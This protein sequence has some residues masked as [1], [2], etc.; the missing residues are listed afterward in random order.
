MRNSVR[1]AHGGPDRGEWLY[2]INAVVKP[3]L[4]DGD[5]GAGCRPYRAVTVALFGGT[6]EYIAP[7]QNAGHEALVLL[8]RDGV[9]RARWRLRYNAGTKKVSIL[10]TCSDSVLDDEL[11]AFRHDLR[12]RQTR[13]R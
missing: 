12:A 6:A 3:A 11:Y 9:W 7:G 8:V 1:V 4:P 5:P 2:V 13:L 10:A